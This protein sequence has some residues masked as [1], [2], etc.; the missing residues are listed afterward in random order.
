MGATGTV[1]AVDN[2]NAEHDDVVLVRE[3]PG[4][5]SCDDA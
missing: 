5:E 2:A 3:Q 1:I 4:D